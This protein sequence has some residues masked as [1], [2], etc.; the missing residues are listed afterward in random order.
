MEEAARDD[1]RSVSFETSIGLSLD[2]TSDK[3]ARLSGIP[4]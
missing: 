4:D 2:L 3:A 1:H